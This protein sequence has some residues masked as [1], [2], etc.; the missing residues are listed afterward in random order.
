MKKTTVFIAAGCACLL[1]AGC[2]ELRTA[3]K[4]MAKWQND[5]D[6]E[7][8][9]QEAS[10]RIANYE[11]FYDQ[12]GTIKATA[13]KAKIAKGEEKEDIVMVL[14]DM[15]ESYNS[16]S[17]QTETKAMWKASDLPYQIDVQELLEDKK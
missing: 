13:A 1:F 8:I 11:W 7:W 6:E 4:E 16:R 9:K 17:C 14:S 5:L 15:V 2:D 10:G 12:Y 3:N